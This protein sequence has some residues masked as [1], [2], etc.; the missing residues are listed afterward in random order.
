ML[1]TADCNRGGHSALLRRLSGT[2]GAGKRIGRV[3]Q[4]PHQ[5]HGSANAGF[6][7]RQS[8]PAAEGGHGGIGYR[9]EADYMIFNI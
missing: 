5:V 3:A 2:H 9:E 4:V 1:G 6:C 7:R 8:A